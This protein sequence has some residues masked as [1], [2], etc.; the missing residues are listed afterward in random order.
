M[1]MVAVRGN[2]CGKGTAENLG[3]IELRVPRIA[4]RDDHAVHRIA[5]SMPETS[6]ARLKKAGILAQ[7]GRKDC[8]GHEVLNRAISKRR[9]ESL[10][11]AGG[12]LAVAR[13]AVF[14]LA[15]ACQ[16]SVPG[17]LYIVEGTPGHDLILLSRRE[18]RN[19]VGV[20]QGQK[21]GQSIKEPVLGSAA[22]LAFFRLSVL[23]LLTLIRGRCIRSGRRLR[24]RATLLRGGSVRFVLRHAAR[25]GGGRGEKQ[26][27]KF[28]N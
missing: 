4:S 18:R 23:A 14:S 13:F 12:T 5:D 15:D 9:P 10:S 2:T 20:F 8:T 21:V 6:F 3:K 24:G 7:Y 17:I 28:T 26:H 25:S 16:E 22:G 1:W 27:P 11:V 19:L